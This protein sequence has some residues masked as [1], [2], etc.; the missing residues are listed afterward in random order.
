MLVKGKVAAVNSFGKNIPLTFV[1]IELADSRRVLE[2]K[3]NVAQ[4]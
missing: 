4:W 3:I 1:W 2:R